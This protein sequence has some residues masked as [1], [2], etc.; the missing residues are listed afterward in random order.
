MPKAIKKSGLSKAKMRRKNAYLTKRVLIRASRAGMIQAAAATE[1][2]M[3]FNVIALNG[4][5]VRRHTDGRIEEISP[6]EQVQ[7]PKGHL[8]FD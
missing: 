6:I 7:L 3:H 4:R 5:I 8:L 2:M 1:A